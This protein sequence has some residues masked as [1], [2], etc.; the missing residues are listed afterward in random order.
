[1]G[2]T[3]A[4]LFLVTCGCL[5]RTVSPQ[6]IIECTVGMWD[7]DRNADELL[8]RTEFDDMMEEFAQK[9]YNGCK[10]DGTSEVTWTQFTCSCTD[11]CDC[12]NSTMVTPGV[13]Q[14]ENYTSTICNQIQENLRAMCYNET[15]G[16]IDPPS[17]RTGTPSPILLDGS[18]SSSG[19][20]GNILLIA[21]PVLVVFF[22]IAVLGAVFCRR[23]KCIAT[24]QDGIRECAPRNKPSPFQSGFGRQE[25]MSGRNNP[26]DYSTTSS[27][28]LHKGETGSQLSTRIMAEHI[29][30]LANTIEPDFLEILYTGSSDQSMPDPRSPSR[31]PRCLD[32]YDEEI[33]VT[34]NIGNG[35]C[36]RISLS[37]CSPGCGN[38]VD[39]LIDLGA[40][41]NPFY[42]PDAPSLLSLVQ[43]Q[44]FSVHREARKNCLE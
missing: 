28:V 42:L 16:V 23:K 21:V 35:T 37:K 24:K 1:M 33:G 36:T 40:T 10:M 13:N 12:T 34:K 20:K 41:S 25:R 11:D 38:F 8:N 4:F 18:N 14:M 27:T 31:H 26:E 22:T 17:K 7:Y 5:W 2:S 3:F 29:D 32:E 44:E 39:E 15:V 9:Y 30:E 6:S 43:S 19:G